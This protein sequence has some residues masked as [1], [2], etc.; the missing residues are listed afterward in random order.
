MIKLQNVHT[1]YL[2]YFQRQRN[3]FLRL[4]ANAFNIIQILQT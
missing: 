1:Q 4:K 3:T 2:K